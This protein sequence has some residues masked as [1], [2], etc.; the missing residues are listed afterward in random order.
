MIKIVR[1]FK[2]SHSVKTLSSK[3]IVKGDNIKF[4]VDNVEQIDNH[5]YLT[6]TADETKNWQVGTYKY[7]I[8]NDEYIESEGAFEVLQNFALVDECETVKTHN[9]IMLE[10]IN[11]Q[12]EGRATA[13]QQAMTVGD[14]SISYC[15]IDELFKL[16]EYFKRKVAEEQGNLLVDGNQMKIKHTWSLR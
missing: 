16:Q 15:S 9:E 14:K 3:L 1:G 10:A 4:T 12:I 8:I 7:Q 6:A 5:Y 2:F 11:A 13:N